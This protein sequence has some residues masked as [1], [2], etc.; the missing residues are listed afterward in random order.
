MLPALPET[1]KVYEHHL[2]AA[3]SELESFGIVDP[4]TFDSKLKVG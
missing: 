1:D 2:A 3:R 4:T